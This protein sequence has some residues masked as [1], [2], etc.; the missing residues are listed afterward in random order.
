MRGEDPAGLKWL[1]SAKTWPIHNKGK[2][3]KRSLLNQYESLDMET[4]ENFNKKFITQLESKGGISIGEILDDF[5]DVN[6][7]SHAV[8]NIFP[9]SEYG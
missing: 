8:Q 7:S 1:T 5:I 2:R 3:K 4:R 6:E 9:P